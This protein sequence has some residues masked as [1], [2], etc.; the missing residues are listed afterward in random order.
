MSEQCFVGVDLG[1]ESGRVIAGHFN[2]DRLRIEEINRFENHPVV[3]NGTLYWDVL[4]LWREILNGLRETV[5]LHGKNIVSIGVDAWGVDFALLGADDQLLGNPVHYRDT[6]TAGMLNTATRAVSREMIFEQTGNQ[7]MQ[8][9]TLYQLL[10]M[11]SGHST[12]LEHAATFLTIPDLFNWML[13]GRKV[14]EFTNATTT[15]CFNPER[16]QWAFEILERLDLPTSIFPEVV[17][18]GCELAMIEGKVG[19]DIG[20]KEIPVIAPATHDTGSAVAAIPTQRTVTASGK[21]TWC[22]LSSGTWSLMG[23]ELTQPIM[24]LDVMENNFTN[25]GGVDQTFRLLKNI[26]GLWLI[27]CCRR[28]W[29]RQEQHWSYQKLTRAAEL[30]P[31][32]QS[33][34]DPDHSQLLNPLNMPEAITSLCRVCEQPVPA[35][36]GALVRCCLESLALK[37]RWVLDRLESVTGAAIEAIHV[38][39]GG[40]KNHLLCQLTADACNRQVIAGPVEATVIGNVLVQARTHGSLGSIHELRDVVQRSFPLKTYDPRS[41]GAWEEAYVRFQ[42]LMEHPA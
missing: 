34:L 24:T 8:I 18:S 36:P 10:A 13:C 1:A 31:P 41:G 16:K 17:E 19:E 39:G 26:M 20:R 29:K 11:R 5:R 4:S 14:V 23:V 3:V 32:F 30:S 35:D 27:Q 9:N 7:F 28:D 6:R 22:F 42:D 15:Q 40:S 12:L 2:G 38:V 25:E 37:Y 21:P 33:I